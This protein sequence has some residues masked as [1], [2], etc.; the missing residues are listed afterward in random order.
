MIRSLK[1]S[2]DGRLL[3]STSDDNTIRVWDINNGHCLL[4]LEGHTDAVLSIDITLD[5]SNIVSG[6]NDNTVRLWDV[7][8]GIC[9]QCL[10]EHT[11]AVNSVVFTLDKSLIISGGLDK[12]II[13]TNL[14]GETITKYQSTE[15]ITCIAVSNEKNEEG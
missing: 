15:K 9:K 5:S 1:F 4:I 3:L 11:A 8:T 13:I 2:F 6:S 10:R 12:Q 14:E 7:P